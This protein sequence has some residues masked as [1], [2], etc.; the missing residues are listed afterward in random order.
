M[1]SAQRTILGLTLQTTK[2]A[3]ALKPMPR[4]DSAMGYLNPSVLMMCLF[5]M[6]SADE[7]PIQPR[8]AATAYTVRAHDALQRHGYTS[9]EFV[10][11]RMCK[12]GSV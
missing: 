1:H 7:M 6:M 11:A 10:S 12:C 9:T 5:T 8:D 2:L 4:P 3:K